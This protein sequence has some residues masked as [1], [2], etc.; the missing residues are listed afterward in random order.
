MTP[1]EAGKL[2]LDL[3]DEIRPNQMRTEYSWVARTL[4]S[5]IG[6][7]EVVL[8]IGSEYGGTLALWSLLATPYARLISVDLPPPG[9]SHEERIFGSKRRPEQGLTLIVADSNLEETRAQVQEALNGSLADY[10]FIDACHSEVAVRRDFELYAP[11]VRYG[12]VIGFHDIIGHDS[13]RNIE[14]YKFWN[15]IK[16]KCSEHVDECIESQYQ[17][18]MG[19]GLLKVNML[20]K[21]VLGF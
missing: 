7:P 12:G 14:V 21:K 17:V 8:E 1:D 4:V 10:C 16:A 2:A 13:A 9:A 15:E 19:I 20:T 6:R 18:C 11:L 3:Y 5:W